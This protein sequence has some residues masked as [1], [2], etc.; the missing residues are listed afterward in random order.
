MQ[1]VAEPS[2]LEA[3]VR[4][5]PPAGA[6]P[7][8]LARV[9]A[10]AKHALGDGTRDL[11]VAT[12]AAWVELLGRYEWAWFATFTFKEAIHPEAADKKFRYWVSK[13]AESYLGKNWRT[14]PK[15]EPQWVRGLEWQKRQVLHYHALVTN[16]PREYVEFAWRVFF[17][18]VWAGLDNGGYGRIDAC[19]GGAAVYAYL[20]KYVVKGG[21]I[22]VSA[23]LRASIPRLPLA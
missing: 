13:V 20:T 9:G 14:K 7:L 8:V 11:V 15:R 6:S 10:G 1:L 18:Q 22:D 19:D 21:E 3:L 2:R 5:K 4:V 17:R 16:L 12:S 23:S